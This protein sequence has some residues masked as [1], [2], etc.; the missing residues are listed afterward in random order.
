MKNQ[1][2]ITFAMIVS[3]ILLPSTSTIY[4]GN[5]NS[6]LYDAALLGKTAKVKALLNKGADV[7]AQDKGVTTLM[8][9]A[10]GGHTEI[11]KLL[12]DKGADVNAKFKD[13]IFFRF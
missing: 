12:L 13:G 3:L 5:L 8:V 2:H 6:D 11:V 7:N 10:F 1:L 9:A 4:A